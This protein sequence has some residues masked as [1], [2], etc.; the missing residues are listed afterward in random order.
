[1]SIVKSMAL[2]AAVAATPLLPISGAA[3]APHFG[4]GHI[5]GMS[6]SGGIPWRIPGGNF[7]GGHHWHGGSGIGLGLLGGAIIG[8]ALAGGYDDGYYDNYDYPYSYD[9][10]Y[11]YYSGS[12]RS[13]S[14]GYCER[15]F[16]S[17]DPA[18]GT[19][20]GYDGLRHS[21]P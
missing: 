19:Y 13:S 5:G 17:Y 20:L 4:M 11:T 12:Y 2:A 16:R 3:A 9:D 10:G 6:R 7:H 14:V 18:S 15:R 8:S 21:C 1:M